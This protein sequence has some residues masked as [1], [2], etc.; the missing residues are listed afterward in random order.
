MVG[1]AGLEPATV[2]LEIR[3]SIRLSYAPALVICLS[4]QEMFQ[5]QQSHSQPPEAHYAAP[6]GPASSY[7]RRRAPPPSAPG[8]AADK[9]GGGK[10]GTLCIPR[11]LC[12]TELVLTP[13][14]AGS[15][16]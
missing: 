1:A 10:S 9:A 11:A 7:A 3:C 4:L 15:H 14:V 6:N 12:K 2:G 13:F 16:L 8:E 5:P